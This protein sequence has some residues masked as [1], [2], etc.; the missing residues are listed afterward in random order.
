MSGIES[1]S[2]EIHERERSPDFSKHS[3]HEHL[4]K[5]REHVEKHDHALSDKE[6]DLADARASAIEKASSQESIKEP[7]R[8]REASPAE[9]RGP[10]TSRQ[11]D[12]QFDHTMEYVREDL[13]VSSRT[14]SKIIHNKAVEKTSDFLATTIVRPNAMLAGA[15]GAFALTLGIYLFAKTMGYK[16]S[17]FEPIAAFIIGWIIGQLYDYFRVMI[18]GKKDL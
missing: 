13:S 11:L 8:P 16:L 7:E 12:K 2:E 10:I 14:F 4:D 18:T 17:G 6:K 3:N 1:K 15:I 5:L 9:R